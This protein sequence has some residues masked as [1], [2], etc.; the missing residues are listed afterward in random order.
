MTIIWRHR[1]NRAIS[2]NALGFDGS[3][4]Q[5]FNKEQEYN[6]FISSEAVLEKGKTYFFF[7]FCH[8]ETF[9]NGITSFQLKKLKEV[10]YL[11]KNFG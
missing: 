4:N 1:R 9:S 8:S 5:G 10:R 3:H 2:P 11:K 7:W 6:A